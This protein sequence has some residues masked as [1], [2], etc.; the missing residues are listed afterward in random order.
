MSRENRVRV[1]V[2]RPTVA[3]HDT[4]IKSSYL[5]D[6]FIDTRVSP[7]NVVVVVAHTYLCTYARL[8]WEAESE[9]HGRHVEFRNRDDSDDNDNNS[10]GNSN[11]NNYY[12]YL[13]LIIV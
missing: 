11:N 7:A 5:L 8:D 4:S 1:R 2:S 6:G 9:K 10:N 13:L 3:V 12:Y